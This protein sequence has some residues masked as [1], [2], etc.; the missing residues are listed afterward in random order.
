ML[1][2]VALVKSFSVEISPQKFS[3]LEAVCGEVFLIY[4]KDY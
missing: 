4:E 1:Q 3:R 2:K